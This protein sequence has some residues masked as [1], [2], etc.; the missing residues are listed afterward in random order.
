MAF[1]AAVVPARGD[2]AFFARFSTFG[3]E[4]GCFTDWTCCGTGAST[5]S[6]GLGCGTSCFSTTSSFFGGSTRSGSGDGT[7]GN[8]ITGSSAACSRTS[9]CMEACES[10]VSGPGARSDSVSGAAASGANSIISA[11]TSAPE[12]PSS[13]LTY[14]N[15]AA[16]AACATTTNATA[17]IQRPRCNSSS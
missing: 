3:F 15:A 17:A 16:I 2:T 13:G 11:G 8:S 1:R 9:G 4:V 14:M 10:K 6:G 5:G 7:G 12:M